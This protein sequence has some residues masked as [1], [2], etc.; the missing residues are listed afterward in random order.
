MNTAL[1]AAG[2]A[3]LTVAGYLIGAAL[4]AAW[5]RWQAD[6]KDTTR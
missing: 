6:R 1:N 5:D 3:A 4:L 2:L